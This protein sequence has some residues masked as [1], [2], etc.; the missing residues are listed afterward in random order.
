MQVAK[1]D[2]ETIIPLL[3]VK[4]LRV[5]SYPNP[6]SCTVIPKKSDAKEWPAGPHGPERV[7]GR[8]GSIPIF[9]Y[10]F[11]FDFK[12][13]RWNMQLMERYF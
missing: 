10:L 6:A 4:A 12:V 2:Q 1:A 3:S 8:I 7:V 11:D 13:N 5:N 9:G